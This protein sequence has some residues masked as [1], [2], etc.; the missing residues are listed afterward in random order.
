MQPKVSVCMTTYNEEELVIKALDS[1]PLRD[2][3]EIVLVE[4]CST[5]NTY[6]NI[7]NYISTHKERN[8]KL[9]HHETNI[10]YGYGT[11]ECYDNASG[12][13]IVELG[14]DDYFLTEEFSKFIDEQLDSNYDLVYFDLINNDGRI[15]NSSQR[16]KWDGAVKF[17]KRSWLGELRAA[18]NRYGWDIELS[19]KMW[20][21]NP[22]AKFTGIILTHWNFPKQN[23]LSWQRIHGKIN[24]I[25]ERV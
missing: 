16:F 18:P 5:D 4:D 17:I 1:I 11:K 20:S 21:L 6:K 8:I 14:S 23:S 2:D 10:G 19:R 12:E 24:S 7:L 22:K 3:I 13:W 9:F 15:Y 25:G